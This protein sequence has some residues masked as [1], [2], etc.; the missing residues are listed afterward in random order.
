MYHL[1][2]EMTALVLPYETFGRH[3]NSSGE[4]IDEALEKKNFKAAG[5]ILS[6]VW[7]SLV[8]DQHSNKAEFI[9]TPTNE[10]TRN[11][12]VTPLFRNRH[13]F[14]TRYMTVYSKCD[15]D[16][17]CSKPKT[18]VSSLFPGRNEMKCGGSSK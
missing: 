15:D 1:S 13:I 9:D 2:K 8:I 14:E 6:E 5:E 17:C 4:T 11:Y 7:S 10:I 18:S 16:S 12:T 3:L